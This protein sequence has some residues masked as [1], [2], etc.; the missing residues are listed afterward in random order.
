VWIHSLSSGDAVTPAV[1]FPTVK[2]TPIAMGFVE[3][4]PFAVMLL[5]GSVVISCLHFLVAA[6]SAQGDVRARRSHD[7]TRDIPMQH[8]LFRTAHQVVML[9]AS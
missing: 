2:R 4:R 8:S 7:Q 6:R 1:P 5:W 3:Q 9:V